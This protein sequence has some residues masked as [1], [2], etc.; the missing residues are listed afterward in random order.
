MGEDPKTTILTHEIH[1]NMLGNDGEKIGT[2]RTPTMQIDGD[3]FIVENMT[4][5]NA[6]GPV[7]QALALRV[8]G[9]K[10]E[11]R[12]CRFLGWQ[13]TLFL[14]RNRQYFRDCYIEGHV[15]FIFG[16]STAFFENCQIHC[17]GNG[18]ITAASTPHEQL[19]GFV[20]K[21]C[22]IT[23]VED[24][25]TFLGRPWRAYSMTVFLNT[26]MSGVVRPEGWNNWRDPAREQTVRYAEFNS[27]GPGA[28]PDERV[29][30]AHR[31]TQ[32]EAEDLSLQTVLGGEEG[33]VPTT[34]N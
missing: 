14:N 16:G 25:R 6:A 24:A 11:F 5:A 29:P 4:I 12:N 28:N 18:Y 2:F 20:F 3:G 8:D 22:R 13:D 23:G 31:L 21:D 27:S 26:E 33:W 7:G 32:E 9:D 10:V 34:S 17:L 30:W 15:D 1:A 19:Y